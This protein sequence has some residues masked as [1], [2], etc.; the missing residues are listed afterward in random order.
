L[1]EKWTCRTHAWVLTTFGSA[2]LGGHI[3]IGH[4]KSTRSRSRAAQ[5]PPPHHNP[6][7]HGRAKSVPSAGAIRSA[8]FPTGVKDMLAR[9]GVQAASC[10]N[11]LVALLD[12]SV[13]PSYIV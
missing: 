10:S 7:S 4:V 9:F 1:G 3:G 11:T 13:D 5:G 12:T 6:V 8:P 2:A